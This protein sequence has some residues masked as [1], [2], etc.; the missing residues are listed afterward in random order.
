M[1]K[2]TVIAGVNGAGKST[3]YYTNYDL[4]KDN[5]VNIDEI[6][7]KI[8][9]WKNH[10]DTIQAGRIAVNML[11]DYLSRGESFNQETTLCG[12]SI[13]STIKKAKNLGY[14]IELHYVGL[15]SAETAKERV[16]KR[17]QLGG[18]GIDNDIIEKRYYESLQNLKEIIPICDS[19]KFYDNT[20]YFI[21]IASYYQGKYINIIEQMPEWAKYVINQANIKTTYY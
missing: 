12:K 9:S 21:Q 16:Q 8:G 14:F 1:K 13:I 17:I 2:Y 15:D 11:K 7:A 4:Y 3:L 10:T 20:K 5:R 18:H 19:I 6:T